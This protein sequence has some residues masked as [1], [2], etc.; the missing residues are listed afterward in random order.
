MTLLL[1]KLLLIYCSQCNKLFLKNLLIYLLNLLKK[2]TADYAACQYHA[3]IYVQ[4]H[5]SS[6]IITAQKKG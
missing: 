5:M 6:K 4:S 2:Q 1:Q 3:V